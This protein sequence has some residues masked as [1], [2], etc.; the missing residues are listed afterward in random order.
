MTRRRAAERGEGRF[1]TL[2]GVAVLAATIYLGVKIIPVM[3]DGYTFRDFLEEEARFAA[4]RNRDDEV[5]ERVLRKARE[6]DLPVGGRNIRI[7][8]NNTWFEIQVRYTVPIEMPFYTW[9]KE[10]DESHRAP[11]F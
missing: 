7:D 11:L 1:G 5:R 9:N 4:L 6:L 10:Y 2:F 3:I 8:R